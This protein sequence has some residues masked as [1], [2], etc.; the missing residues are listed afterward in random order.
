MVGGGIIATEET[1]HTGEKI[2]TGEMM[3]S[4][5]M[6]TVEGKRDLGEVTSAE[7]ETI[8]E[9]ETTANQNLDGRRSEMCRMG[10]I[11]YLTLSLTGQIL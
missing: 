5:D 7:K 8:P 4:A 1:I 10:Q 11:L 2:E 3:D 9:D 6:M